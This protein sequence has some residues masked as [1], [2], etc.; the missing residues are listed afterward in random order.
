MNIPMPDDKI[1]G[2]NIT[3]L[4]FYNNITKVSVSG[5]NSFQI[6]M[7]GELY[8]SYGDNSSVSTDTSGR[9][10]SSVCY[11]PGLDNLNKVLFPED[12]SKTKIIDI[13]NGVKQVSHALFDNGNLYMWGLNTYGACGLGHNTAVGYPVLTATNV[14]KVYTHPTNGGFDVNHNKSVILKTDGRLYTCGYNANGQLGLGSITNA[15]TWTV[16]SGIIPGTVKNVWNLGTTYGC[17]VVQLKDNTILICGYNVYGDLGAA[18][19]INKTTLTDVTAAWGGA[20]PLINVTGGFGYNGGSFSTMYMLNESGEARSCGSNTWYGIGN[21]SS[22]H[23]NTPYL[24]PLPHMAKQITAN[25]GGPV[26]GHVLLLNGDLYSWG[27]GFFNQ[28]GVVLGGDVSVPTIVDHKVNRILIDGGSNNISGHITQVVY[29]RINGDIISTGY[30]S[31]DLIYR[32]SGVDS[33]TTLLAKVKLPAGT[34]VKLL[35]RGSNDSYG[36][37]YLLVT[38]DRKIYVWGYNWNKLISEVANVGISTPVRININT[39][40]NN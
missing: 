14:V 10:L 25:G 32:G 33:R 34:K 22:I 35:G 30:E 15:N 40:L 18:D 6:L 38:T 4:N 8:T 3:N 17:L 16:V 5:Y 37:V 13:G 9:G 2:K 19:N 28:T 21:N 26:T 1:L 27:Y 7:D 36:N 12:T 24:L 29:E 31:V 23:I 39:N 11:K 20:I